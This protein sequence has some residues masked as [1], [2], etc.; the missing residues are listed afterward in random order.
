MS[1]ISPLEL[2]VLTG[3]LDGTHLHLTAE[4]AWTRQPGSPLSFPWDT[5]LGQPQA[6][7]VP[8]E[9]GWRLEPANAK[10]GTHLLRPDAE[11][12]LPA[13]LQAG[14]VL[15]ASHTWLRV[16]EAEE[17]PPGPP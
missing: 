17:S 8:G 9:Q 1:E 11:D 12:E 4:T 10:R 2:E 7:F 5:E 13:T 3:P 15:K 14:D 16:C 6:R